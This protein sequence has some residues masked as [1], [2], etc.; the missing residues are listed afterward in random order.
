ME[1]NFS[2]NCM[3][4]L[5]IFYHQLKSARFFSFTKWRDFGAAVEFVKLQRPN[6]KIVAIGFSFGAIEVC[7]YLSMTGKKSLVDAAMLISCPYHPV[8]I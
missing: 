4:T 5:S 3:P 8:S 7:R 6:A 2:T 1:C